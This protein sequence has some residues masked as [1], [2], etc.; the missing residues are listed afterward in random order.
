MYEL[1]SLRQPL[2]YF[3]FKPQVD[4][5]NIPVSEPLSGQYHLFPRN[6]IIIACTLFVLLSTSTIDQS[7]K[8]RV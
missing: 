3:F 8:P 4:D 1:P 5:E 2:T 7:G 6:D